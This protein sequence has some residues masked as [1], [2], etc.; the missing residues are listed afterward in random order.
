MKR[1]SMAAMLLVTALGLT[2][3]GGQGTGAAASQEAAQ[4]AQTGE[5]GGEQSEE[6]DG[7]ELTGTD[8]PEAS[9]PEEGTELD[10]GFSV[11]SGS[12]P[13]ITIEAK[14]I[15]DK[16]CFQFVKD[17]KT[18]WNLGN[19]LDAY[20][21]GKMYGDDISSEEIWGN[22]VTTKEMIDTLKNAGFRTVRIPVTWHN[23]VTDD[24]NGPV[25]SEAW[26]D[27][28]QEVVDYAYDN[29]MYVILNTHHDNTAN[30]E[31]EGGYYPDTAHAEES[32]RYIRGIWTQVAE[33]F[34]DY[35]EHLIFES[36]NEPRLA[37]TDYEWNFNAGVAECKDAAGS[38]NRL[39]Q[40]F[41][42]T[43]RATG[44]NNVERYLMMPGY[45]ASLAGAITDLYQLPND[46]V[47]DK[48]IVSVHAYT[49]YN[50]ALRPGNESEATDYFS[51]ED[52]K[53]VYEIND[54]MNS[55][56]NKFVS[57]GIPVVIGEYGAVNRDNNTQD[58]VDYYAYYTAA[59]RAN[60]ITCCVWDNGSFTDG[61]IFGILHRRVNQW[62]FEET[63]EAMMKYS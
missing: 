13:E 55:L 16:E 37:G 12:I 30:I 9:K 27:R 25:I 56:Y 31:G 32:D 52:P 2:A 44:G 11:E 7:D 57:K 8:A 53:S 59:A 20:S 14:Q 58:R 35:D 24:G 36:L 18:G 51:W 22:P 21:Q 40:L 17:M 47:S 48:L 23:H 42:D 28:V 29:G 34:K 6:A 60:G 63:V 54:L 4:E 38:I 45:D 43:V 46:I 33:R 61:E 39:N 15:P 62:F 50:F 10:P 1:K 26:L 3:C 5:A 49:P 41:V 19:T